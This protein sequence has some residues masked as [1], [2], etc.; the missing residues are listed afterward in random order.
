MSGT[1][2]V[3]PHLAITGEF[4]SGQ[5]DNVNKEDSNE[6]YRTMEVYGRMEGRRGRTLL[7]LLASQIKSSW[8]NV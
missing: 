5:K 6:G 4:P 2:E 3:S 8:N 7:P 1:G